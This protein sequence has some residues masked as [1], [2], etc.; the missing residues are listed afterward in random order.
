MFV[1]SFSLQPSQTLDPLPCRESPLLPTLD[2]PA[3][4]PSREGEIPS[5]QPGHAA[6]HSALLSWRDMYWPEFRTLQHEFS[7]VVS[8]LYEVLSALTPAHF[9]SLLFYLRERLKPTVNGCLP[10][11]QPADLPKGTVSPSALLQH[12]QNRWDYLNTDL[13]EDIIRHICEGILQHVSVTASSLQSLM[14]KYKENVCSK[15]TRTLEECER[16]KVKLSAPPNYT[17]MAFEMNPGGSPLSFHLRQILDLKDVL[18]RRFGV[19]GALFAGWSEGSIVLYFFI[20]E[21]AVYSL[22]PKLESDCASLQR[23]H[24]TTVVVFGHFSVDV[25]YQQMSLLHK[26][27]VACCSSTWEVCE[28]GGVASRRWYVRNRAAEQK[29]RSAGCVSYQCVHYCLVLS[30]CSVAVAVWV[31]RTT[32]HTS[33][34]SSAQQ[35]S[36]VL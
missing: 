15:V 6:L 32:G 25:G 35:Q 31:S 13:I 20:P 27:G 21:E 10:T 7:T 16:K 24:V 14:T 34:V 18:V 12:L 23:L 30:Q 11:G 33:V 36:C 28:L 26:V 3:P 29:W 19:C 4:G 8:K 5:E 9:D 2:L 22:C 17:T 1:L